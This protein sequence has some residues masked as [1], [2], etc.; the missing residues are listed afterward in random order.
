MVSVGTAGHLYLSVGDGATSDYVALAGVDNPNI[1]YTK[2]GFSAPPPA[3][4][5]YVALSRSR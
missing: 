4:G 1:F 5:D 2:G 3:P